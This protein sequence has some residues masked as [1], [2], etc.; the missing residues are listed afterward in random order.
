MNKRTAPTVEELK[1]KLESYK[2]FYQ[3]LHN[4]QI[5]ID[6]FY[7]LTFDIGIP[8]RYQKRMPSTARDWIDAGVRNFT[9]DNPKS[10]VYPRRG[11]QEARKQAGLIETFYDFWLKKD[12]REIKNAAKKVLIRGEGF[13]RINMDDTYF[14]NYGG[15]P[16]SKLSEEEIEEYHDERLHHF[17]LYLTS[18]D[19]INV[20]AS[21][22]HDGMMP[23]DIFENFTIT[24]S[25]ANA[26]ADR[27]GWGWHTDKKSDT[28][29]DWIAYHDP[30]WRCFLLDGEPVFSP[31]VQVNIFGFVPYV[32]FSSGS[33]QT[34]YQ[35]K[36]EYLYRSL[37]YGKQDMLKMEARTL[38]MID[39]INARYAWLRY[40]L[41]GNPE[42]IKKYY[43]NGVPTDP[44]K[45]LIEIPDSLEIKTLAGENPPQGLFNE[46]GLLQSLAAP[47]NVLGAV[48][49]AGVYSG[50]LQEDLMSSAKSMYKDAFQNIEEALSVSMGMGARIVDRVYNFPVAIKNFA[51]E[52]SKTYLQIQPSDIKGLY[53]CE[54]KLLAE[55][56]EANDVRKALGKALWQG[57]AISLHRFLTEY[58]DM[59]EKE[60]EDEMAQIRAETA[61]NEPVVREV[62]AKDAMKQLGMNQQLAII[63]QIQQ[64][65]NAM[66]R[67]GG[68]GGVISP[69]PPN[70]TGEGMGVMEDALR[71]GNRA[72]SEM[73]GVPTPR[74]QALAP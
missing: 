22:A 9:L 3:T 30:W 41:R 74:E 70:Q 12:I 44:D 34:S 7:E 49:P 11:T 54:V 18:P 10:R 68:G 59:S 35:G 36:P 15:V 72:T 66:K 62:L 56:P 4:N 17:P 32:H 14:G 29:I 23:M 58:C 67:G 69:I 28:E 16:I 40:V 60:A 6:A 13:L 45:L 26:L 8:P 19:P 27:N 1:T 37:I 63:N 43:P 53:D 48:K 38:S 52:E 61:M 50:M 31:E 24:A 39:A 47:P 33:G 25:E 42:L 20:F 64:Q 21:P 57:G 2:N 46:W 55:P 5:D 73:G 65:A 71:T 51:S